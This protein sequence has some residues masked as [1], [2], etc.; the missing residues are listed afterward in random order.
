MRAARCPSKF[1]TFRSLKSSTLGLVGTLLSFSFLFVS[2]FASRF[3]PNMAMSFAR[4]PLR[5]VGFSSCPFYRAAV[6]TAHR[7][8]RFA[9]SV[10][11]SLD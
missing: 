8:Q 10:I 3:K 9:P 11:A 1:G 4:Q 7:V 6:N 2:S 5:I